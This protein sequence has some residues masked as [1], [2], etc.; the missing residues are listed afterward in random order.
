MANPPVSRTTTPG[1]RLSSGAWRFAGLAMILVLATLLGTASL[2][3]LWRDNTAKPGPATASTSPGPTEVSTSEPTHHASPTWKALRRTIRPARWACFGSLVG[4]AW[5]L[6]RLKYARAAKA[7]RWAS[8]FA[9]FA[10]VSISVFS[11]ERRPLEQQYKPDCVQYADSAKQLATGNGYVTMLYENRP[12]P[13]RYPP[14]YPICLA[15]FAFF[16]EFPANVQLGAA[17]W[18]WVYLAVI[19]FTAAYLGGAIAGGLAAMLVGSAPFL[20]LSAAV[21]LSDALG[22]ALCV[23]L[24]PLAKRP[25][26]GT[27]LAMGAVV[28]FSVTV[29]IVMVLHML[30]AA[31]AVPRRLWIWLAIGMLP[32]VCALGL[33]HWHAFGSPLKTGYGYWKPKLQPFG[34]QYVSAAPKKMDG[35][36][37]IAD[38]LDGLAIEWALPPSRSGPQASM[39]N[40]LFYPALLAGFLWVFAPPFITG[41]GLIYMIPRWREAP[42]RCGLGIIAINLG[43]FI[44]Y[45]Y[46]GTRFMAGPASILLVYSAIALSSG[47]RPRQRVSPQPL[48]QLA[49]WQSRPE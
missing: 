11:V 28:G 39:P 3:Q 2:G 8:L 4:L 31:L 19:T 49:S 36:S 21:I 22:A 10:L 16:G 33:Y 30:V 13:P 5:L 38:A 45:F 12:Q 47:W 42:I 48:E 46:Q 34:V 27:A 26:R 9:A 6:G 40:V 24:V 43:L 17:F 14:G 44:F 41:A 18:T 25:T 35:P 7:A 1:A 23:L 37:V 15:P 32:F 20:D 29:R